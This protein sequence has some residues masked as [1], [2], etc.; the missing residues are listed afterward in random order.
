ME[1]DDYLNLSKIYN[2]LY[3]KYLIKYNRSSITSL[4][5]SFFEMTSN[6]RYEL[7]KES[8][9]DKHSLL[10]S[11]A[12]LLLTKGYIRETGNKKGYSITA[13]GIYYIEKK[14]HKIDDE[15]LISYIDDK[16]FDIFSTYEKE[17]NSKQK[18][19]VFSLIAARAFSIESPVDLKR[20]K[21]TKEIWTQITL[22][23]NDFLSKMGAIDKIEEDQLFGKAG[24]EE[25]VSN[26][27]RHL[28]EQL[29]KLTD[30]IFKTN[31]NKQQYYLDLSI[32]GKI[33]NEKLS[34]LLKKVLNNITLESYQ[35]NEIYTFCK[36]ISQSNDVYIYKR[37]QHVFSDI[38]YDREIKEILLNI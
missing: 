9:L 38:E 37:K 30:N 7:L 28:G 22:N 23:S 8:S 34:Y 3:D 29:P 24:N 35:I 20:D 1:N 15:K 16:Y 12:D 6:T 19:A 17:L 32:K 4:L 2:R 14:D 13:K 27:Y 18:V 36:E 10:K 26:F 21:K 33:I 5:L 11:E 31:S 25:P